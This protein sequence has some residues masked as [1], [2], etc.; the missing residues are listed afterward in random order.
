M[1]E[2][3]PAH[4]DQRPSG[5]HADFDYAPDRSRWRQ[6]STYSGA[7]ET[8]LYLGGLLEK[9]TSKGV[10]HWKHLIPTPSG[11]VQVI[12]RSSGANETFYVATDH[13]GS[14]DVVMNAAGAVLARP[15]FAAYGARRN[16][17]TWNGSPTSLEWQAIADTTRRGFTGHEHLDNVMLVHM[18]GRVFDPVVGRFTSADPYVDCP[19]STQGW[20]RYSYVKG[21]V[22]SASDPTGFFVSSPKKMVSL[23]LGLIVEAPRINPT[24]AATLEFGLS[25][26]VTQQ[27][28]PRG[29][30]GKIE[31]ANKSKSK[32]DCT[33]RC[34]QTLGP[35][36]A[37]VSGALGGAAGGAFGAP[38]APLA[39]AAI[40][41]FSG[42]VI[43]LVNGSFADQS[44]ELRTWASAS[45]GAVMGAEAALLQGGKQSIRT[46]AST[47]LGSTVAVIDGGLGNFVGG[48]A[49]SG[50]ANIPGVLVAVVVATT[51]DKK[52]ES[53]VDS[54]CA[55][56]C[57]K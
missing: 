5:H 32:S 48:I 33:D 22:L 41:A 45:T 26:G 51:L 36:A 15:S 21:Q 24:G 52:A 42:A 37:A 3:Q 23:D 43:G 1:V 30:A 29:G 56:K 28:E 53:L 11:Q 7:T 4:R 35:I 46:I 20:N 6:V 54:Y 14:T 49:G 50:G 34:K 39:G 13:L 9:F 10:T 18:N 40:G 17:T 27:P 25:M 8:T 38:E 2:L 57:S 31:S 47:M 55:S 16:A 12:R 44:A 19:E